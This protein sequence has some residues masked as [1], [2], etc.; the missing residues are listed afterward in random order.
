MSEDFYGEDLAYIHAEGFGQLAAAAAGVVQ[1]EA[2]G[3]GLVLDIG[4]GAGTLSA[5]LSRAG[6]QVWGLD[7][8]D[9]FVRLARRRVPDGEFVT[10]S[11][12]GAD[13]PKAAVIC[14]IGEVVNYLADPGNSPETLRAFFLKAYAALPPGGLLLFDAAA[15]GRSSGGVR[16][17]TEGDGWAVGAV[18]EPQDDRQLVRRVV[19]FRDLGEGRWRRS[20]E[21]HRLRLWSRETI[22]AGLRETG[23]EAEAGEGYGAFALPPDLPSY[24]ARK[25][26]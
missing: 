3:R 14:A 8:S 2:T 24:R 10:G 20:V 18:S 6:F 19:T 22:L 17:F 25:P 21:L 7:I 4:C 23:F 1:A 5:E 26:A 12:F 15:P 13:F 11:I 16:S 9:A